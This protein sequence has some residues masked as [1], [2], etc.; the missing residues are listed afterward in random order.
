MLCSRTQLSKL[1]LFHLKLV[2]YD[3]SKSDT[4]FA[5]KIDGIT[6]MWSCLHMLIFQC[7]VIQELYKVK[8]TDKT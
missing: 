7:A 8:V 1:Q 3:G 6:K 5:V 4:K 2:T